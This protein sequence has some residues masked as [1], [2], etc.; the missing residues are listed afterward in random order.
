VGSGGGRIGEAKT[1]IHSKDTSS[2]SGNASFNTARREHPCVAGNDEHL[3]F[4]VFTEIR[5]H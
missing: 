2:L 5:A 1:R 3:R 4:W